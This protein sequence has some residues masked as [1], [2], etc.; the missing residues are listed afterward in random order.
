MLTFIARSVIFC[1]VMTNDKTKTETEV[2]VLRGR[3]GVCKTLIG[4]LLL[5]YYRKNDNKALL[6][7]ANGITENKFQNLYDSNHY[8][9]LLIA[10][11]PDEE[12]NPPCL[13]SP[14]QTITLSLE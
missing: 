2:I 4:A 14:R 9:Y 1:L 8:Q 13:Q 6:F 12:F 7:D 11:L 5:D 10:I 3:A